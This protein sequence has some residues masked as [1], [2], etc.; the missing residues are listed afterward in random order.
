MPRRNR[1]GRL[2][3]FMN[4]RHVGRLQ[5]AA[6][7]AIGFRYEPG[8]I[9]EPNAIP[10]SLSLPLREDRYAGAPVLAVF[11]NLLPDSADIRRALAERNRAGGT[12]AYSLLE[13]IGRDCVGALQF[14]PDGEAPGT[15]GELRGRPLDD[16]EVAAILDDLQVSP[17][18]NRPE[19]EVRISVAG[20]QEK[21][22]LLWRDGRWCE[23][24]GATA[25]THILKPAIGVTNGLD[26]RLSVENEYLCM[27]LCAAF[28]LPVAETK[29]VTFGR[30]R[31]LAVERFDRIWTGD[32]RLLRAPQEDCCQ[33]LSVPPTRKYESDGGPGMPAILD[34]LGAADDPETDRRTFLKAQIVFWLLAAVDGHA[35]NFSLR[36][37]PGGR[38]QL[39]PLYD[40]MSAQPNIDAGEMRRSQAKL[41]MAVGA[42]RHYRLDT[43]APRHFVQTAAAAGLPERY[44]TDAAAAVLADAEAGIG[45]VLSDLPPGFPQALAASVCDGIRTRLEV[46]ERAAKER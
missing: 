43:I 22:A 36:L 19:R 16:A 17:L 21:T 6:D 41:A 13:A 29:I 26:L 45:R 30:H 39:A 28:G 18:G 14:L 37:F 5:R 8:W 25:T 9:A 23:P 2:N 20:A 35:K 24:L 1:S 4:G 40:V 27:R 31:V 34:L 38:L 15:A 42:N 12:D 32:D 11:D 44:A 7:G 10:V 46:V 3:V 33:A